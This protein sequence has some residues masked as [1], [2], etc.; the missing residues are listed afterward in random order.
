MSPTRFASVPNE[1]GTE[2]RS[3]S[4]GNIGEGAIQER[5]LEGGEG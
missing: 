1:P 3:E 5:W 4:Q 2:S